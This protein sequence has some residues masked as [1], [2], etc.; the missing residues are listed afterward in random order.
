MRRLV[1]SAIVLTCLA[2]ALPRAHAEEPSGEDL[3]N[4]LE[5][6]FGQNQGKRRGHAKGFCV[7]GQF[8]PADG[9]AALTKAAIFSKP[10]PILGRFSLGGGNPAI[11]DTVKGAVRG[12]GFRVDPDGANPVDFVLISAPVHFAKTG[13]QMLEFLKLRVKPAYAEAPDAAAIKAFADAHPETT[14]QGEWLSARPLPASYATVNYYSVHAFT[15][16]NAEGAKTPVKFK[17]LPQAGEVGLTDE[18]AKAKSADFY[19]DELTTRLAAGPASFDVVAVLGEAADPLDDPTAI[20][21]DAERKSVKLGVVSI[22][23]FEADATCDAT[24]F[25]PANVAD[26]IEPPAND[27]IFALRSPAYAVSLTRRSN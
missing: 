9:A 26:G 14:R 2:V 4:G 16:V 5:A 11:P 13:A 27:A 24:T 10:A 1:S 19:K 8:A 25:D 3:V 12:F 18:D 15:A 21:P 17:L 6:V 7:K 22:T 23:G 20:W